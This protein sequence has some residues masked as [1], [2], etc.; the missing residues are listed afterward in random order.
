MLPF[1]SL[2]SPPFC[3]WANRPQYSFSGAPQFFYWAL[4]VRPGPVAWFGR[5]QWPSPEVSYAPKQGHKNIGTTGFSWQNLQAVLLSWKNAK[6]C[7]SQL[8]TKADSFPFAAHNF[9]ENCLAEP[10][11]TCWKP[12]LIEIC[13]GSLSLPPA[14][15]ETYLG[16]WTGQ[17]YSL[18]WILTGPNDFV[19][20]SV[21][22]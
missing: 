19:K 13:S 20:G 2:L 18:G 15:W 5:F 1:R 6:F 17:L 8:L 11:I 16:L 12:V 9:N 22:A 3:G 4:A 7:G 21:V 10:Q 14:D